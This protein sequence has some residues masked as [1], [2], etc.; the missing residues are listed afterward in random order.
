[1]RRWDVCRILRNCGRVAGAAFLGHHLAYRHQ[2]RSL[3]MGPPHT[4]NDASLAAE[5]KANVTAATTRAGMIHNLP[6]V[7][8][9]GEEAHGTVSPVTRN[10]AASEQVMQL[11]SSNDFPFKLYGEDTRAS[12]ND[13][14]CVFS[15]ST[16]HS[17]DP[18]AFVVEATARD[19][20]DSNSDSVGTSGGNDNMNINGSLA[21]PRQFF[22]GDP[23]QERATVA[24]VAAV[25]MAM[26]ADV[27]RAAE[28]VPS[29]VFQQP[30]SQQQL[31]VDPGPAPLRFL[32][33]QSPTDSGKEEDQQRGA[34]SAEEASLVEENDEL[35]GTGHDKSTTNGTGS[36]GRVFVRDH[37]R[38]AVVVE[39]LLLFA[40]IAAR[41]PPWLRKG[42]EEAGYTTPTLVQSVAIPL[43]MEKRDVVGIAPTGSGKTVAFALPALAALATRPTLSNSDDDDTNN[44]RRNDGNRSPT[45]GSA[46]VL[47][48]PEVLVLCPTRELVQQTRDVFSQL[49][50]NSVRV[51]AAFGG[52]DREKQ[53]Q[54]LQRWGGCDVLVS[55]PGRL[56]DFVEAGAVS[57]KRID[58]LIMD[59][60]DRMLELGF[61]PQLEFIM[62]SIKKHK[63]PRQTTMWTATWNATV[64]NLAARFMLPERVFLEVDR[65]HQTNTDITQRLY[66]LKDA[67]QRIDAI[68]RLYSD[69]AISKRQQV[70]MFANRKESATQLVE[71]LKRA[72]RAP[73]DLVQCL[74]GGMKQRKR[75]AILQGFKEG[76]IRI[77]CATDVAA[78]GLD[79]PALDHVI[80]YDIPADTDAYVHRI[81]RTGRAGR[82]G[83]AHTLIVAGDGNAPLIARYI[84]AQTGIALPDDVLAIIREVELRGGSAP[85][86]YKYKSHA[87]MVGRDW[88]LPSNQTPTLAKGSRYVR[89][90]GRVVTLRRPTPHK[91]E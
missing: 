42:L 32:R 65:A 61:A 22:E 27:K 58:F 17:Y 14:N 29:A 54:H 69:G 34:T 67:S 21:D 51:K 16:T 48:G 74:H 85:E 77:L 5:T 79:V 25:A 75:E 47:V 12:V 1:M 30:P 81:G 68:V 13:A 9:G 20:H 37:M 90:I 78:R 26:T 80:N 60:A 62:S 39:R 53:L 2:L 70:L 46:E 43:F 35:T 73:P 66:A 88:R 3:K 57:L 63:R 24:S 31:K 76:S 36:K 82:H 44:N 55:T 86:R 84:A 19:G 28:H 83:T 11:Y 87:Q 10:G 6:S 7:S 8:G 71:N 40:E 41:L 72:L 38:N 18:A 91:E 4:G 56:C 23:R 15:S 52:Q 59:E 64:G 49:S 45:N 33:K 89:G 50:M